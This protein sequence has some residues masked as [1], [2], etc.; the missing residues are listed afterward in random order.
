[1]IEQPLL[2]H[3]LVFVDET[4]AKGFL[5][6][7]AILQPADLAV[8]RRT[9]RRLVLPGQKRLHMKEER[10]SR[11]QQILKA[12][13]EINPDIVIFRASS[14]YGNEVPAH[15]ACI[16]ALTHFAVKAEHLELVLEL[17]ETQQRNDEI[18]LISA[19][20]HYGASAKLAYRHARASE[21]PLLSIPDAVGW[22]WA[23]GG[24]WRSRCD[25]L[26]IDVVDVR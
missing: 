26:R 16:Y 5:L 22:A 9:M 13:A 1:V 19:M 15:A 23:R 2:R 14:G 7:A 4:K 3:G 8:G 11:K 25:G 6:V 18:R 10:D 12:V 17:D 21:E 24:E 20:K